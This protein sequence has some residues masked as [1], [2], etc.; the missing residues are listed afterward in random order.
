MSPLS[1]LSGITLAVSCAQKRESGGRWGRRLQA[2]VR[3]APSDSPPRD[4]PSSPPHWGG[5][6]GRAR[7]CGFPVIRVIS[8]PTAT[9]L[10]TGYPLI[11]FG[12]PLLD[13][14]EAT[15]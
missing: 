10:L 3:P 14:G 15:P 11:P 8:G 7:D 6:R 13:R 4:F 1:L 9:R 5:G 2:F 12:S